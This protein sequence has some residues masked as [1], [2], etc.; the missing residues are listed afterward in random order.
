MTKGKRGIRENG[1][2]LVELMIVLVIIGVLAAIA[3]PNML[4]AKVRAQQRATVAELRNWGIALGS[5]MAEVGTVP[6]GGSPVAASTIHNALVPYAVS[7]LHDQD[8]WKN[9][10]V[11]FAAS[12]GFPTNYT[13]GSPGRG[14]FGFFDD[15]YVECINEATRFI[16][17]YDIAIS[18]GL[19]ICSP[20]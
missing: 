18:D 3:I 9:D 2:S 19:F 13:V 10:L 1:F 7:A 5:Y 16:Y 17:S 15:T 8:A 6:L 20:S 4:D 11:Y 12:S 14:D